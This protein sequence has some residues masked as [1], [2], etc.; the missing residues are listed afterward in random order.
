ML[1]YPDALSLKHA[2]RYFHSFVDTGVKL[3]VAWLVERRRL[4]L[5][6]PS[7]GR[8]DLGTDMRFCRGSVALLMKR[9]RE[10][11]ECQSR[12]DLGCIVLGTPTC[13]HRPAGHQYRVLLAR[14]IMDEWSSEMQ[15]LF[16]AAA[17]VACS[18]ACARW[19]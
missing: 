3:K 4:H 2:N 19:L 12:P 15:W 14:M 8:C 18:W 16:V 7:E 1:S 6:C 10:H 9:R 17:V 5:D 11:I 13:P